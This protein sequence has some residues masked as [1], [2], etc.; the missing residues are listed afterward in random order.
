MPLN[1]SEGRYP[2]ARA[3]IKI[4][5]SWP[6][7]RQT[8]PVAV[9]NRWLVGSAGSGSLSHV[10]TE[11]LKMTTGIKLVHVSYRG[12]D[13]PAITDLLGG[14]MQVYFGT[15]P[16][17]IEYVRAGNL[18][19]PAVTSSARTPALPDIPA[20]REFL[21]SFEASVL[22][23]GL[24]APGNTPAEIVDKPWFGARF[25]SWAADQTR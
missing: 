10:V 23:N 15:L 22:W 25:G 16:A 1:F 18:R 6:P 24:N 13:A 19:A 21:P 3:A 5:G 17:S 12:G 8:K 7:P 14:H 11:L 9:S 20:L 2:A 4:A